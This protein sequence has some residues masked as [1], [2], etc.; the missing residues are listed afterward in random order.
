VLP[1]LDRLAGLGDSGPGLVRWAET[2]TVN[3]IASPSTL[4]FRTRGRRGRGDGALVGVT[5]GSSF[6]EKSY[7]GMVRSG[8]EDARTS[9]DPEPRR[10]SRPLDRM[11]DEGHWSMVSRGRRRDSEES[12]GGAAKEAA[13]PVSS[14]SRETYSAGTAR[15]R[16]RHAQSSIIRHSIT[17]RRGPASLTARTSLS[18]RPRPD[19]SHHD[20]ITP[21]VVRDSRFGSNPWRR[22]GRRGLVR[23][24]RL[25]VLIDSYEHR[26]RPQNGAESWR[27]PGRSD[28]AA[29][30]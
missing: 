10:S 8:G 21:D 23:P 3:V 5:V 19:D 25:D 28:T 12:S 22:S 15:I 20:P 11:P 17:V 6:T 2:V 24:P 14:S 27:A 13:N 30:P 1:S 7:R 16:H 26:M 18:L 9:A 4:D 29:A